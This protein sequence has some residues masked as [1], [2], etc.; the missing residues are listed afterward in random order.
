MWSE[1]GSIRSALW[2]KLTWSHIKVILHIKNPA[3]REYYLT[4][5]VESNWSARALERQVHAFYYERLLSSRDEKSVIQEIIEKTDHLVKDPFDFIKD[6]FVL[7][8]LKIPQDTKYLE[9][10]IETA[11]I[12]HLQE[13]LLELGNGLKYTAACLYLM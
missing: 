11:I 4:E 8:F 9:K 5:T 10:D 13:F 1:S 3:A 2:S 7:E 12:S 6:P